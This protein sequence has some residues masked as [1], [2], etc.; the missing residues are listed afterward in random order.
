MTQR[1]EHPAIWEKKIPI[2]GLSSSDYVYEI[3]N[4]IYANFV[5]L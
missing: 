3:G 4:I 5:L 1:I 2:Y